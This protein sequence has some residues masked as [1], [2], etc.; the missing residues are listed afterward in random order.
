MRNFNGERLGMAMGCCAFARVALAEAV[1][2]A[3]SRETFGKKLGQHQAMRIKLA[4]C[5]RQI[6]ATGAPVDEIR[7]A[8]HACVDELVERGLLAADPE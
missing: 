7:S 5:A 8:V 1:E 4:D 6:A 3:K 2:W